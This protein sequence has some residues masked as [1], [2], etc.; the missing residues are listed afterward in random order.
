MVSIEIN[1]QKSDLKENATLKDAIELSKA[2][3]IPG[4]TIGILKTGTQKEQATSEYKIIT[5]KGELRI[6]LSGDAGL[7]NKFSHDFPGTNAHWETIHT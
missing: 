6:E 5:S 1:G 4:T 7:W 2:F 3:Y